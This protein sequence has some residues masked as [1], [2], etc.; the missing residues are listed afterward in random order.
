MPGDFSSTLLG[1]TEEIGLN[2][3]ER[4]HERYIILYVF[5]ILR[6]EVDDP[7]SFTVK[8]SAKRGLTLRNTLKLAGKPALRRVI[9]GSFGAKA[10]KLF[11]SLPRFIREYQ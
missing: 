1:Q 3:M 4:R 10:V 5:K 6:K 7:G 2:S 11:D 8:H 9:E